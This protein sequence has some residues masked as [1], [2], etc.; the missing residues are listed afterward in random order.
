MSHIKTH[1]YRSHED[2]N[3]TGFVPVGPDTEWTAPHNR[4]RLADSTATA[5]GVDS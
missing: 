2:I 3:P 1:Y 4:D 5:I